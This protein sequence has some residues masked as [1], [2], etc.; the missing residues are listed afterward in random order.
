M[1]LPVVNKLREITIMWQNLQTEEQ[2]LPLI[3]AMDLASIV[4]REEHIY[5]CDNGFSFLDYSQLRFILM[6]V[7]YP[8]QTEHCSL[9]RKGASNFRL[10]FFIMKCRTSCQIFHSRTQQSLGTVVELTWWSLDFIVNEK[11]ISWL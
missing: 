9:C 3:E 11:D 7:L 2:I 1:V 5:S 10:L 8:P 6:L 4:N